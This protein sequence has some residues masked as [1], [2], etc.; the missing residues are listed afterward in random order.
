MVNFTLVVLKCDG[1]SKVGK[2]GGVY[3]RYKFRV[4]FLNLGEGNDGCANNLCR[5]DDQFW[6]IGERL[7]TITHTV[8][9][10]GLGLG[11]EMTWFNDNMQTENTQQI[12]GRMIVMLLYIPVSDNSV[13]WMIC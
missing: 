5:C 6:R 8:V 7:G 1:I 9:F 4:S 12:V 10:V 3:L 2:V 11:L 13:C